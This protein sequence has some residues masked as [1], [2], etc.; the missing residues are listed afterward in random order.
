[1]RPDAAWMRFIKREE[2]THRTTG[3]IR[4]SR[5]RTG[6][7]RRKDDSA[8]N[9]ESPGGQRHAPGRGDAEMHL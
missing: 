6:K 2:R 4:L 9:R 8:G 3:H 1:M 7:D 5:R